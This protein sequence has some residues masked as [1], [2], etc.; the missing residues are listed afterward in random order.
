MSSTLDRF[1]SPGI[2]L[3]QVAR[4]SIKFAI[5]S[6]AFMVPLCVAV[7][8]VVSYSK[9]NIEFAQ[10][11]ELGT[12]FLPSMNKF[13]DSLSARRAGGGSS[14]TGAGSDALDQA[15]VVNQSQDNALAIDQ[16][17]RRLQASWKSDAIEDTAAQALSLYGLISDNSKLTL[18]PDLDSYYAMAIVMD[19][20]PKLAETAARF[21]ALALQIKAAGTV[22]SADDAA[23]QFIAARAS[24]YRDSLTLAIKRAIGANPSLSSKLNGSKLEQAYFDFTTQA[25]KL[26][27]GDLTAAQ[28][29]V[30]GKLSDETMSV[31]TA[32]TGVLNDLLAIRIDGFEHQRNVLLAITLIGLSIAVYLIAAFYWSNVRGFDALMTRMRKLAQGDLTTNYPARGT[33]EIAQL[34]NAFNGSRG[35]LQN[36]VQRIREVTGEID[37][38]GQQIASS[39]DELAQR[40]ASQSSAVRMTAERAQQVQG[41]VQRNLDNALQGERLSTDARG[42]AS[43][44][45]QAVGQVVQ[46]MQAI[47]SS[48]RKIGDIIGVIDDIAFQ[49]NLLALN[50]AVEAARAG[51]QGR[52]FAVVASEVR[53][54]AQRSATAANEIKKLIGASLED[55]QKGAALVNSA[56]DT[57]KEILASVESVSHIM[58]EIAMAS[59]TQSDDI[60]QLHQSI[61]RIDG[62]TH[63]NAARVEETAAV[64][65]SLRGQVET[66]LDAVGMFTLSSDVARAKS[67]TTSHA[68]TVTP[69]THE[70]EQT[71]R[72]AA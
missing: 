55:V 38:A 64:A 57:M 51:E 48:S 28:P 17:L 49:T 72:S 9:S 59:R 12:A 16:E 67:E 4:L 52:G 50:A 44:G 37:S 11:E 54:L 58:Q 15:T 61:D 43:R 33:D 23:I 69:S 20:A 46:T 30:G 68:A 53:S 26:R 5:I 13:M 34:L 21:D 32:T 63:Q 42:V 60:A 6:T 47:T 7:Y 18:D 31:S 8:G 41:N 62:D 22:S 65:Q 1:L 70:N 71:L 10:Q 36:L 56:G 27:K 29:G 66:L 40:E 39:N 2:Q 35:Q 14:A 3:M 19:Y 45:N 25:E 24:T